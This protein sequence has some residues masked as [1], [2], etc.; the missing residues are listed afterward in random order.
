MSWASLCKTE[1][2]ESGNRHAIL[3]MTE[4]VDGSPIS[5]LKPGA[6]LDIGGSRLEDATRERLA[7]I[8]SN[9]ATTGCSITLPDEMLY[10]GTG[11]QIWSRI[12]YHPDYYQ[13]L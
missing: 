7:R 10:D 1:P 13:T 6:I 11:H 8:L 9:A 5:Q 4:N 3:T 2:H 12:I